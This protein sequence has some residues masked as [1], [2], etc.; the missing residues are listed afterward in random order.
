MLTSIFCY[1]IVVNLETHSAKIFFICTRVYKEALVSDCAI[2]AQDIDSRLSL[3]LVK[4]TPDPLL[5]VSS[6]QENTGKSATGSRQEA[7]KS[8]RQK[9]SMCCVGCQRFFTW[10]QEE[11]LPSPF[12]QNLK[13]VIKEALGSPKD[14]INIDKYTHVSAACVLLLRNKKVYRQGKKQRRCC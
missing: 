5:I 1:I 10:V 9:C 3:Y 11:A 6:L 4:N 2:L 12:Y 7:E 13:E 8:N 14:V